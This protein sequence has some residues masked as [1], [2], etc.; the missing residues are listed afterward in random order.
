MKLE[1]YILSELF[2]IDRM[3]NVGVFFKYSYLRFLPTVPIAHMNHVGHVSVMSSSSF[4]HWLHL[5]V[6]GFCCCW[7]FFLIVVVLFRFLL[8]LFFQYIWWFFF[9]FIAFTID[10]IISPFKI[11][12]QNVMLSLR[13]MNGIVSVS[14]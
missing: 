2:P 7:I 4:Y 11:E 6:L 9:C 14:T 3:R 13:H 10:I 8:L 12:L 5:V 1:N